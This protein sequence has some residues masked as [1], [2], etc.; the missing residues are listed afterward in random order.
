M[1]KIKKNIFTFAIIPSE[2]EIRTEASTGLEG[3]KWNYEVLSSVMLS[4]L[5]L[6]Q[7]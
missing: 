4:E 6:I 1:M 5:S 7:P 3:V 2:G